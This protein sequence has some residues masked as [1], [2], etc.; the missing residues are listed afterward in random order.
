MTTTSPQCCS[1]LARLVGTN[2]ANHSIT[3][4]G[5]RE[6]GRG[7]GQL[8]K[9]MSGTASTYNSLKTAWKSTQDSTACSGPRCRGPLEH[10]VTSYQQSIAAYIS[11]TCNATVQDAQSKNILEL[12]PKVC[13]LLMQEGSQCSNCLLFTGAATLL[14]MLAV[15]PC[16]MPMQAMS[17]G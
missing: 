10:A 8:R 6:A 17:S 2:A 7:W 1:L 9:C 14:L 11:T 5:A 4:L 15:G 3:L 12:M 16:L 13:S